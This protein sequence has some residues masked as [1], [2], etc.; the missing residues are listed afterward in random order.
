MVTDSED[1]N[2]TFGFFPDI[3]SKELWGESLTIC[4]C[5][6]KHSD[7]TVSTVAK[8]I[9]RGEQAAN[10]PELGEENKT[11]EQNQRP[12]FEQPLNQVLYNS[13]LG[14]HVSPTHLQS[15]AQEAVSRW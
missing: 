12:Q 11:P 13:F 14:P 8:R 1:S 15:K 3:L 9:E 2:H 4:C 10:D 7:F 6:D 5:C